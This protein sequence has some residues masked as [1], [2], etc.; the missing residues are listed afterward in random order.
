MAK[1]GACCAGKAGKHPAHHCC[2]LLDEF[3]V[4]LVDIPVHCDALRGGGV[5][6]NFEPWHWWYE[7]EIWL[8]ADC[9]RDDAMFL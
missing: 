5:C 2:V 9:L 7:G 8:S 4:P 6:A 1:Q 3:F